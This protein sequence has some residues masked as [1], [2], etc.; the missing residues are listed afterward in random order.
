MPQAAPASASVPIDPNTG[1]PQHLGNGVSIMCLDISNFDA[2]QDLDIMKR[3][4]FAHL[5]LCRPLCAR[6]EG[7][8]RWHVDE[9]MSYATSGNATLSIYATKLISG[10]K[11]ALKNLRV[12]LVRV[13]A[14]CSVFS[15]DPH[16]TTWGNTMRQTHIL[17]YGAYHIKIG[18]KRLLDYISFMA[19]GDDLLIMYPTQLTAQMVLL[20][21]TM[22]GT[23]QGQKEHG[24]G[25]VVKEIMTT[26]GAGKFL[27]K[28]IQFE[29]VEGN[30]KSVAVYR[31][32][33]KLLETGVWSVNQR[34]DLIKDEVFNYIVSQCLDSQ[35]VTDSLAA[36]LRDQRQSLPQSSQ[37]SKRDKH[38]FSSEAD[39]YWKTVTHSRDGHRLVDADWLVQDEDIRLAYSGADATCILARVRGL[40]CAA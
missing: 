21:D 25:Y 32:V 36:Y 20:V 11:F 7:W 9:W 22:Y 39:H 2:H 8:T 3:I 40:A 26:Q 5:K 13:L 6:L 15:G 23:K 31:P 28:N 33:Q 10:V 24:C 27:S 14:W 29:I 35:V 18:D 1:K 34:R 19:S 16:K 37:I 12:L 17:I 4:D 30:V 38:H